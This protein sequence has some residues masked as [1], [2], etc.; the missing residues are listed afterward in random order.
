MVEL[1][2]RIVSRLLFTPCDY[3]SLMAALFHGILSSNLASR[4]D[5]EA[6][7]RERR[8]GGG[9]CVCDWG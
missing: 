5:N 7:E 4:K 8:C 6:L 3:N 2:V 9:V 1:G